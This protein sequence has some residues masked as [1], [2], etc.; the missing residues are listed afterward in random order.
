MKKIILMMMV[1][2]CLGLNYSTSGQK[3]GSQ[4]KGLTKVSVQWAQHAKQSSQEFFVWLSNQIVM[5]TQAWDGSPPGDSCNAQV[6]LGFAC[7][8]H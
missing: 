1:M 7:H 5:G 8:C 4:T 2:T 3:T 6:G